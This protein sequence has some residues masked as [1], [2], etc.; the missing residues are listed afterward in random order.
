MFA[1]SFAWDRL[2]PA[3]IF[4]RLI[5][6]IESLGPFFRSQREQLIEKEGVEAANKVFPEY[7]VKD[8]ESVRDLVKDSNNFPK[9]TVIE[10]PTADTAP[11][12][13]EPGKE[14]VAVKKLLRRRTVRVRRRTGIP[15][16][17]QQR[18]LAMNRP[19]LSRKVILAKRRG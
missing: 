17:N 2:V 3:S 16:L 10:K 13:G 8:I 9:Q 11:S 7:I 6:K 4:E 19:L 12:F 14:A 1:E 18:P 15:I 5:Y